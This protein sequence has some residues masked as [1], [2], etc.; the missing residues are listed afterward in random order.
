MTM[1][2]QR[3]SEPVERGP[4]PAELVQMARI[5]RRYYLEGRSKLAIAEEL[6]LSRF[7]VARSLRKARDSGLVRISIYV[8][9]DT[10][11]NE[12]EHS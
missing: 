9:G 12:E 3:R 6:G 2:T 8:P 10:A 11:P 7:Q 5:A 1:L 4:G